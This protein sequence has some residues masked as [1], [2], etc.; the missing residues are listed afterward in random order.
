MEGYFEDGEWRF[1]PGDAVNRAEA[2]QIA[3]HVGSATGATP[4]FKKIHD[5]YTT[6]KTANKPVGDIFDD[7]PF[8]EWF[9]FPVYALHLFDGDDAGKEEDGII[10]GQGNTGKYVPAGTLNRAE[11]A[12]IGCLAAGFC[13]PKPC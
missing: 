8:G 1:K 4:R 7:V 2:A 9:Y 12:K 11:M 5:Y 13:L 6:L 10:C 3:V